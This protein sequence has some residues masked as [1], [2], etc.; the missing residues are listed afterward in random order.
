MI[1]HVDP[2]LGR[3]QRSSAVGSVAAK[4]QRLGPGGRARGLRTHGVEGGGAGGLAT[5]AAGL[6]ANKTASSSQGFLDDVG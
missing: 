4:L 3:F 6:S 5:R 2:D 1:F